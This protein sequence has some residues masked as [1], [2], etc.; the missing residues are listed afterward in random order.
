VSTA[1][2]SYQAAL[3]EWAI[4][5]AELE[6]PVFPVYGPFKKQVC[7]CPKGRACKH[8]GKHPL[9]RLAPNGLLDATTDAEQVV[10]WWHAWP[11]ANIG[12]AVPLGYVVLDI[13]GGDGL[14]ALAAR[15]W[16]IP[17][18]VTATTSRGWHHWFSADVEIRPGSDFMPHIDLRG[19]GGYVVAPPSLHASGAQYEWER[20]PLGSPI[21]PAPDWL[22]QLVAE[23]RTRHHR[24]A[25]A[26]DDEPIGEGKR[27][28]TLAR[29]AGAMRRWGCSERAILAAL[30]ITNDER[31]R[32]P[33][34][35]DEL[36]IIAQSVAR[37]TP[38]QIADRL[39]Q[40]WE[41]APW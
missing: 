29:I 13:D 4:A 31:C 15:R 26:S 39:P 1:A 18:T 32:P 8:A 35:A 9:A 3:A 37:Y 34:D 33:L 25:E 6:W 24:V 28:D 38:E 7:Q 12:I 41:R 10:R 11:R 30:E 22:Y 20:S 27:N 2:E 14:D 40:V 16:T 23:A 21:A 36:A 17:E 5:Y 19:P